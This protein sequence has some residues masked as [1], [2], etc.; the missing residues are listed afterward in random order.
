MPLCLLIHPLTKHL[1]GILSHEIEIHDIMRDFEDMPLGGPGGGEAVFEIVE[2]LCK[3]KVMMAAY[4]RA[5]WMTYHL[6]LILEVRWWRFGGVVDVDGKLA[7]YGDEF[8]GAVEDD[9]VDLAELGLGG[10]DTGDDLVLI[11]SG[12]YVLLE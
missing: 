5:L 9:G 3:V 1:C 2:G 8:G 10:W 12:L 7:S 11:G 6:D 4:L